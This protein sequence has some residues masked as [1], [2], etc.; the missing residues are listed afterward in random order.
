[1]RIQKSFSVDEILLRMY[2]KSDSNKSVMSARLDVVV[3]DNGDGK[4]SETDLFL[5]RFCN[6]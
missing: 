1:M 4:H 3:D 5:F 2:S 6:L